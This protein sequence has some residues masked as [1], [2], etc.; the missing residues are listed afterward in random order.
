MAA[1]LRVLPRES[2]SR[3]EMSFHEKLLT[4]CLQARALHSCG[5][6]HQS[7]LVRR[8]LVT[9]IMIIDSL[10]DLAAT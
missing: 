6:V 1:S 7:C 3:F 5:P 9:G 8:Y 2:F 10:F 4:F